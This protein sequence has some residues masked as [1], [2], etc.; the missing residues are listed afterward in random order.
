MND[1]HKAVNKVLEEHELSSEA[2]GVLET[3]LYSR[4]KPYRLFI[5]DERYPTTPDWLIARTSYDAI[6]FTREFGMPTEIAFDHDLGGIDTAIVY[7]NWLEY[8]LMDDLTTFPPDFT[9]SIHSQNPIGAANIKSKMDQ[10]ILH[11]KE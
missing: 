9:Y 11:F 5:D 1:I 2:R 6:H 4:P 3:A 8:R 10:L 7:I